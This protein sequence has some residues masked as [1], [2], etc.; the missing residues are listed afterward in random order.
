MIEGVKSS[1]LMYKFLMDL[2]IDIPASVIVAFLWIFRAEL[3]G[4]CDI[5][6]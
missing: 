6:P 2:F 5:T 4:Y 1:S 3:D